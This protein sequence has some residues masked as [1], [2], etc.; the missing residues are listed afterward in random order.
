M[1]K[2]HF[3]PWNFRYSAKVAVVLLLSWSTL[4]IAFLKCIVSWLYFSFFNLALFTQNA[5]VKVVYS[6][7][8]R[9]STKGAVILLLSWTTLHLA[10]WKYT[11]SLLYFFYFVLPRFT[12]KTSTKV[13][14][15][16]NFRC[17]MKEA[18][19]LLFLSWRILYI[20]VWKYIV[21]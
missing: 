19:I 17:S 21:T 14:F 10:V 3:F 7:N 9:C 15:S 16:W 5:S 18:V 1:C 11:V 8:F 2:S 13:I 6:W 20:S 4:C 12:Q